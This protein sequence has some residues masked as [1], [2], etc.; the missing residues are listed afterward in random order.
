MLR[1][2]RGS[3]TCTLIEVAWPREEIALGKS[4]TGVFDRATAKTAVTKTA[5]ASKEKITFRT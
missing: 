1:T 3:R 4:N 5:T 2:P